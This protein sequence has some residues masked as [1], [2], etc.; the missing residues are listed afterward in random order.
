MKF[1][2]TFFILVSFSF[3]VNSQNGVIQ[4]SE[5]F[6]DR[7][8]YSILGESEDAFF[9]ERKYNSRFNGREGDIE[10]LRFDQELELTH[11]VR[12]K[13]IEKSSYV[14]IATVN[15]PEGLAHIYYQTTKGGEHFVSAQLFNSHRPKEN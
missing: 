7:G 11:A 3:T 13:D 15:S 14:S 5:E 12:L 9:I 8:Y 4:W 2:L 1:Y 6:D 10:L